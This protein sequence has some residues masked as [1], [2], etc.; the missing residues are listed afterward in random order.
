MAAARLTPRTALPRWDHCKCTIFCLADMQEAKWQANSLVGQPLDGNVPPRSPSSF[1]CQGPEPDTN[2]TGAWCGQRCPTQSAPALK[3]QNCICMAGHAR[4]TISR[5]WS[6]VVQ[7]S[8][9]SAVAA[10]L[11]PRVTA[12]SQH[13]SWCSQ[14][15]GMGLETGVAYRANC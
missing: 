9:S 7:P 13:P 5:P 4:D 14:L 10:E 2:C 1:H 6:S 8:M 15:L 11:A 3:Q 12:M